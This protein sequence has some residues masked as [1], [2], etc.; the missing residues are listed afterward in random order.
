MATDEEKRTYL[1]ANGDADLNFL[2]EEAEMT[3]DHQYQLILAG[4]K[5]PKKIQYIADSLAAARVAFTQLLAID[6]ATAAGRLALSA[7]L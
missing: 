6:A 5:T 2:L 7:C 3:L 4:F 1:N